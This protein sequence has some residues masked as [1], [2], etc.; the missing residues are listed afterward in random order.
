MT[1]Y[2]PAERALLQFIESI[3]ITAVIAGLFSASTLITTDGPIDWRRVIFAFGLAVS[4][5]LAH[6]LV[7][8]FKPNDLTLSEVIEAMMQALEK[9]SQTQPLPVQGPLVVVH[10]QGT[11]VSTPQVTPGTPQAPLPEDTQ[12]RPAV[13]VHT[14]PS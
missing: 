2:T 11:T 13:V 8:Y 12:P 5:S 3:F 1:K 10:P 7:A 4:F 9:R 14:Q 6:S